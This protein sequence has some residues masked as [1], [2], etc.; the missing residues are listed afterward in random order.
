MYSSIG[1][2]QFVRMH[3]M[4]PPPQL[5]LDL[6]SRTRVPGMAA[7]QDSIRGWEYSVETLADVLNQAVAQA[8]I[9]TYAASNQLSPV[10]SV[11]YN[12]IALPY[13]VLIKKVEPVDVET[14][15]QSVGGLSGYSNALV[16]A[17]WTLVSWPI[18]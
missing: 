13:N 3:P 7:W 8:L 15:L 4:P 9:H 1:I 16:A 12:G 18:S 11:T 6:D 10:Q 5:T 17:R 2:F 14:V